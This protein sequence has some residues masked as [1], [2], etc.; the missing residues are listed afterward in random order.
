MKTAKFATSTQ[1]PQSLRRSPELSSPVEDSP[2]LSPTINIFSGLSKLITPSGAT[3]TVSKATSIVAVTSEENNSN[4]NTK[5]VQKF[6][7]EIKTDSSGKSFINN[8]H[9]PGSCK[10]RVYHGK[11][12]RR[13]C[14]ADISKKGKCKYHY[15]KMQKKFPFVY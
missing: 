9:R 10:M 6:E 7:G 1:S 11:N 5:Q 12:A 14:N 15:R 4:K 8:E 2:P 3:K 13:H